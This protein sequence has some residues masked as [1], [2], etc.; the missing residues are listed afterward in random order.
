MNVSIADFLKRQITLKKHIDLG[1]APK[2]DFRQEDVQS[3]SDEDAEDKTK[4]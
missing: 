2:K 4:S 3:E 1:K